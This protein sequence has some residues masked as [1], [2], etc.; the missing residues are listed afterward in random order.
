MVVSG[1]AAATVLGED[2]VLFATGWELD[3]PPMTRPA[4]AC[5]A[6]WS[7]AT[8]G[9]EMLPSWFGGLTPRPPARQASLTP[10]LQQQPN[11]LSR[12][13][14]QKVT[15]ETHIPANIRAK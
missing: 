2:G 6:A 4:T 9:G 1:G 14:V 15:H 5:F 10:P 11:R 3:V 8:C 7:L 13:H 12:T